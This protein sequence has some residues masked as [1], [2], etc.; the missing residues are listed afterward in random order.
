[1]ESLGDTTVR[2]ARGSQGRTEADIQSDV[3]KFLLD[4]PLDIDQGELIDV[5][6]EAQA[7]AG[8]RI[9]VEA[10]AVPL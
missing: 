2:L 7:G 1:M 9:D 8:R 5:A 3:R 6:L 10:G 4:A